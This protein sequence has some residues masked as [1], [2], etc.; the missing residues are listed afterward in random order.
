M[1]S[2]ERE[3]KREKSREMR[4]Y[5]IQTNMNKV[6]RQAQQLIDKTH[7]DLKRK[8]QVLSPPRRYG[9]PNPQERFEQVLGS[10]M[11]ALEG[12]RWY[13]DQDQKSKYSIA[14]PSN[15][16]WSS[17]PVARQHEQFP[18]PLALRDSGSAVRAKQR[19]LEPS[20]PLKSI[21]S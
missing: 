19:S 9:S 2:E 18:Q 11:Q 14:H 6:Q 7:R 5:K 16:V 20:Q 3:R 13:W 21:V 17:L 1:D 12:G 10:D 8:K 15:V 4:N